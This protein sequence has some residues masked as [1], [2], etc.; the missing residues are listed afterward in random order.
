MNYYEILFAM[1]QH[2]KYSIT[3]VEEM[4]PFERDI[5]L[6]KIKELI[7]ERKKKQ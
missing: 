5:H 6:M 1:T 3:E 7:E 2:H 4:Y